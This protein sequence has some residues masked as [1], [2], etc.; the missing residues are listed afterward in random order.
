[1]RKICLFAIFVFYQPVCSG[2]NYIIDTDGAHASINFKINHRG[3]SLLTGRF[4]NFSGRF[5][6]NA[7][8]QE[9]TWVSVEIDMS[10][11]DTNHPTRDSFLK[12]AAVLNAESYKKAVF[13]GDNYTS[14]SDSEGVLSGILSLNG[15]SKKIEIKAKKIG[16]GADMWGGYRVGFSGETSI[17]LKDY[18]IL[19]DFGEASKYVEMEIHIEGIK[20]NL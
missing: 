5:F 7:E 4:N 6:Y 15:V 11:V 12:S 18:G 10:S 19:Y 8:K 9:S 14:L 2:S 1:M 20:S 17:R 16:E 3:F 13:T